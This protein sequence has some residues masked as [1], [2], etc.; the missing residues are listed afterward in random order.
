VA[1]GA[2]TRKQDSKGLD[3]LAAL[4]PHLKLNILSV[5]QKSGD[6]DEEKDIPDTVPPKVL[7]LEELTEGKLQSFSLADLRS[8]VTDGFLVKDKFLETIRSSITVQNV[9]DEC[10]RL[11]EAGKLKPAKMKHGSAGTN[12]SSQDTRGDKICWLTTESSAV[13]KTLMVALD[14]LRVELNE[15]AGFNSA[16]THTQLACYE[17]DGTRYVRHRDTYEGGPKRRLTVIYYANVA[18]QASHGGEIRVYAAHGPKNIEPVA[19]RVLIFLSSWLEHEVL[20]SH[21][22]RYAITTW[23]A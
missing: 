18:W 21:H 6:L 19:D 13:L 4:P 11:L 3:L 10:Q 16:E 14:N 8:L 20:A 7:S 22:P 15:A 17:E 1:P 12:W 5:L 23:F 9:A 2:A